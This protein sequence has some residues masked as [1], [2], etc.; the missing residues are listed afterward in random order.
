MQYPQV[1]Y[2]HFFLNNLKK[3][4]LLM[5]QEKVKKKQW[6][7][8]FTFI[9]LKC[10]QCIQIRKHFGVATTNAKIQQALAGPLFFLGGGGKRALHLRAT[11]GF[12]VGSWSQI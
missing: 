6:I 9:L 1:S 10:R 7:F 4:G 12:E 11:F 2:F 5:R 3:T 8:N